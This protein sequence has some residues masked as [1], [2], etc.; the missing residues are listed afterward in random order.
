MKVELIK[1]IKGEIAGYCFMCPGCKR[2]HVLID[3][4]E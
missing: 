2:Y 4:E 1:N 3:V